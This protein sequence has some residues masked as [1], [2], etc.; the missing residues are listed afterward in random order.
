MF[1][2][3]AMPTLL[4]EDMST[5]GRAMLLDH[6][7]ADLSTDHRESLL[8]DPEHLGLH[9]EAWCADVD[10]CWLAEVLSRDDLQRLASLAWESLLARLP[11]WR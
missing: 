4:F 9:A 6:R 5:Q 8:T 7:L 2:E 3:A 10:P 11:S 1:D